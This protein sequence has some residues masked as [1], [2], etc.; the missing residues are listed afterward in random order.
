MSL[1]SLMCW[2][3]YWWIYQ[4]SVKEQYKH[5]CQ[6]QFNKWHFTLLHVLIPNESSLGISYKT[7]KKT[8]LSWRTLT[9]TNSDNMPIHK[10]TIWSL[11]N[12][13][14]LIFFH[15]HMP[16]IILII[17]TAVLYMII[18]LI[19]YKHSRWFILEGQLIKTTWKIV[20]AVILGFIA[21]PSLW[22]LYL[23]DEIY[24]PAF[25]L[26]AVGHQWYWSYE[27]SDFTKLEF[28]SDIIPQEEQKAKT[29]Q[30][31]NKYNP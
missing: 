31:L 3:W 10:T 15:D 27:C 19:W 4:L 29:F 26:K 8:R 17:I 30:L 24:N 18:T 16:I 13:R 21:I 14:K 23:I 12:H 25:T 6:T 5:F 2:Y 7:F 9:R 20:P 22:L 11:P 28:N 1:W